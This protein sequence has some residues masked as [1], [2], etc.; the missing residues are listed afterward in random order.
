MA[1]LSLDFD[2]PTRSH[3]SGRIVDGDPP[4]S[5]DGSDDRGRDQGLNNPDLLLHRL[6]G[7]AGLRQDRLQDLACSSPS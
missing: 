7:A 1:T 2:I 3:L 4:C 6:E 5:S